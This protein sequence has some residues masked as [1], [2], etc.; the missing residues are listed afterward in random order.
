VFVT[1]RTEA[2]ASLSASP[3]HYIYINGN[4]ATALTAVVGDELW[5]ADG[6]S[7]RIVAINHERLRGLYNPQTLHGDLIVDGVVV[8]TY[9]TAV[10]PRFAHAA[11]LGPARALYRA[12]AGAMLV[13]LLDYGASTLARWLPPG[14]PVVA[15]M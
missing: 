12:K 6:S 15:D 3:G 7:T 13:G 4:L 2:G 11:L 14:A 10:E 9:T 8:S 5:L 1:L